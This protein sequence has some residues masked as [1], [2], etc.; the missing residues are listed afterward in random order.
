MAY[1]VSTGTARGF[2]ARTYGKFN[3]ICKRGA[4]GNVSLERRP[5]TP[6]PAELQAIAGDWFRRA[7]EPM[8][9]YLE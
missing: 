4:D 5:T 9:S 3:L 1:A 7:M 2:S 8:Q 6:V